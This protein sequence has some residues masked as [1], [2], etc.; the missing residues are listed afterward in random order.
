MVLLLSAF[1]QLGGRIG[2]VSPA[3][4]DF[5]GQV[6]AELQMRILDGP[7]NIFS[8]CCCMSMLDGDIGRQISVLLL[9]CPNTCFLCR[10]FT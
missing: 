5:L 8:M 7:V 2:S 6:T 1:A 9:G 3:V 10:C 4:D